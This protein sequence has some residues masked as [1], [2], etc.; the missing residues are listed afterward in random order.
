[1]ATKKKTD[2]GAALT[3]LV[4]GAVVLFLVLTSIVMITNAHYRNRETA[5]ATR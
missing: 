5:A 4:L 2:L 3:G 1:M